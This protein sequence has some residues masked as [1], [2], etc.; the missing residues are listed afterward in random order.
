VAEW[1]RLSDIEAA[2]K[3]AVGRNLFWQELYLQEPVVY[4]GRH[5]WGPESDQW[6][7]N[8]SIS[9]ALLPHTAQPRHLRD[10]DG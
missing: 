3:R 9:K 10:D 4:E 8:L 2:R 6:R 1:L 5:R 7:I